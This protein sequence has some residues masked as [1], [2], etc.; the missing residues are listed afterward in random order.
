MSTKVSRGVRA[1]LLGLGAAFALGAVGTGSA[2][3]LR[4]EPPGTAFVGRGTASA[5]FT[6][7]NGSGPTVTCTT[8]TFTG[9]TGAAG[10]TS[11][12]VTPSYSGGGSTPAHC[13]SNIGGGRR[14]A[15]VSTPGT[16]TLTVTGGM[17]PSYTG[18][19]RINGGVTI[20]IAGLTCQIHIAPGTV[21]SGGGVND[22]GSPPTGTTINPTGSSISV[23]FTTTG[24]CLGVNSALPAEYTGPVHTPG[25]YVAP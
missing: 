25:I 9:T 12:D 21:V 14:D 7:N 17:L 5:V 2:S 20:S 3:A 1:G 24:T 10:S 18:T 13:T 11:V 19:V 8:T 6:T 16:W 15:T 23:P 22:A 4:I